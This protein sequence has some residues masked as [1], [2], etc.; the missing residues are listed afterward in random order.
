MVKARWQMFQNGDYSQNNNLEKKIF[1]STASEMPQLRFKNPR[2]VALEDNNNNI[3]TA[4]ENNTTTTYTTLTLKPFKI[5]GSFCII[6][7]KQ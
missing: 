3:T 1:L 5:P 4:V 7:S 6:L 2:N